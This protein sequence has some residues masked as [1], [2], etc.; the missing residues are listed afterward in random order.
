[1]KPMCVHS[2]KGLCSALEAA[3]HRER[4]AIAEYRRFQEECDYPDI[5]SILAE[6]IRNREETLTFLGEKRAALKAKF[7]TLDEITESF[8]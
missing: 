8:Q 4:Q 2:C 5:R 3:D 6:L 1:M 7:D